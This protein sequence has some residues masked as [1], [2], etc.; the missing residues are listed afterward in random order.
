MTGALCRTDVDA[1]ALLVQCASDLANV[2]NRRVTSGLA[3]C[4]RWRHRPS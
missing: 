4:R 2:R 1:V 3:G